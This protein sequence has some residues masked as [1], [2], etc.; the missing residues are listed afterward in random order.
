[1]GR[2]VVANL[3]RKRAKTPSDGK[4]YV[5]KRKSSSDQ[6]NVKLGVVEES[7]GSRGDLRNEESIVTP[8]EILGDVTDMNSLRN[9]IQ[10]S[11]CS[12]IY[13]L[14]GVYSWWSS[15]KGVY[16]KVNVEG[17][18]NLCRAASEAGRTIRIVHVSTILAYGRVKDV[19]GSLLGLT[20]ETAFDESHKP[21]KTTSLY[22]S[23]KQRG[24]SVFENFFADAPS[25]FL[26]GVLVYLAC[27]IGADPKLIDPK[28]DVMRISDLVYEKIPATIAGDAVFTYIYV[29][30]A[31]E[32]IVR[33]G[34][35]L[36]DDLKVQGSI[37]IFVGDQRLAT[38][39]YYA[40]IADL[41][42]S[43]LKRKVSVPQY[44]VPAKV[45]LWWAKVTSANRWFA[46]TVSFGR[47]NMPPQA[48]PDVVRTATAGTFLFKCNRSQDYL[49]MHYTDIRVAFK[50]AVQ[51][52][53]EHTTS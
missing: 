50:E 18:S 21:G 13:N 8:V 12:V 34:E 45:A 36:K 31:A 6:A 27:C 16:E 40:L 19:N 11:N 20:L 9:A 15:D 28:K 51:F 41:A 38:R 2:H 43:Q 53:V 10:S 7:V 44:E 3:L 42:S 48:A 24:D 46:S 29:R 49:G 26:S 33:A 32:A 14:A 52:V 35:K 25:D 22:A 30:D 5:L 39:S 4:V 37:K 23:S 47:W 17:V 1:M